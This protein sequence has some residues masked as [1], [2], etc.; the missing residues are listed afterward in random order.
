MLR[1]D[2]ATRRVLVAHALASVGM[3]LPWP[4]LLVLVWTQTED[5]LLLG[6][7]AALRMLP[8]VL[9]SWAGGRLAD[10]RARDRL[11]M[12][13]LLGRVLA[14]GVAGAG[15]LT[16]RLWLAVAG[17]TVA[18]AVATPAY[19]ALAAALPGLAGR[20]YRAATDR[21]VTVEAGGFVVGPALG[22]L[23]LAPA[24][25]PWVP[26][27]SALLV[28]LAAAVIAGVRMPAPSLARPGGAP[29]DP[30][31]GGTGGRGADPGSP[32]VGLRATLRGS[33]ALR[34]SLA[35]MALVNLVFGLVAVALVPIADQRW[36]GDAH[37]FGL[38]SAA[39]GFGG[40]GAPLL[41]RLAPTVVRRV[42]RGAAL[43]G[44]MLLV[45]AAAPQVRLALLPLAAAG[46]LAISVEGAATGILQDGVGDHLRA[47]VLGLGD[48]VM[49]GAAL[50]GS[51]VGPLLVGLAGPVPV[52]LGS[53]LAFGSGAVLVG[54]SRPVAAPAP[55]HA[56]GTRWLDRTRAR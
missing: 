33:V 50:V 4:L 30:R 23:A 45:T 40:L 9:L 6:V 24:T 38:A 42:R 34:G 22:G 10:R 11:V 43:G 44:L 52:L 14:L 12:A 21:L 27:A 31:P 36:A 1:L 29:G 37:A 49:L 55:R 25:R 7:T 28:A 20:E 54:R 56:A 13:T 5:P 35:V 8:G 47:S 3:S 18:V 53:A 48:S 41:G 46:A 2:W 15:V 51:L 39:L 19:P 17:C 32:P 16:D 26:A